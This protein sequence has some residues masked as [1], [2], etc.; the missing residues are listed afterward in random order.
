MNQK[1][2]IIFDMDGTLWDSSDKVVDAWNEIIE[3]KKGA[4][5]RITVEQMQAVMGKTMDVLAAMLFPTLSENDR[6]ALMEECC[7][8]ENEYLREH[9]AILYPKLCETLETLKEKY[10]LFIV[11]NCQSGYIE[12][13]LDHYDI[14]NYFEDIECYGNNQLPKGDNIA[15]VV[16]RNHL[17]QA[18]YVGDI[19]GDYEAATQAGIMFIHAAYGFGQVNADVPRIQAFEDLPQTLCKLF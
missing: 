8:H 1:P 14:W 12:S 9:G 17:E 16:S 7:D 10:R 4:E 6:M 19:Q 5:Y 3:K 13:F 18:V 15:L 11:S 2:G